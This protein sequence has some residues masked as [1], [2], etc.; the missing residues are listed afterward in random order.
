MKLREQKKKHNELLKELRSLNDKESLD[1]KE[2]KRF[3]ELYK[4]TQTLKTEIEKRQTIKDLELSIVPEQKE[5]KPERRFSLM[6]AIKGLARGRVE[7]F[8]AEYDQ[9]ARRQGHPVQSQGILIPASEVYGEPP[10]LET[11]IV[12]NAIQLVSS[13]VKSSEYQGALY[14]RALMPK[15]GAH[16]ISVVGDFSYPTS[17]GVSSGWWDHDGT[18]SI[19]ESDPSYTTKTLT[20]KALGTLSGWSL[21]MLTQLS[22]ND[23]SLE[24]ILREDM[25]ASMASALDQACFKSTGAGT[26]ANAPKGLIQLLTDAT[27]RET[28]KDLTTEQKKWALSDLT[29]EIQELQQD[30]KM[31][32]S[33]LS[34]VTSP[35]VSRELSEQQKFSQSNG[36]ALKEGGMIIDLPSGVTNWLQATAPATATGDIEV[37]VGDFSKFMIA[38][39]G[40]IELSLGQVDDD[41]KKAI[42]RLRA[43]SL[44]DFSLRRSEF[45]PHDPL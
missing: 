31:G 33:K 14:E 2:Q 29:K 30:T 6:R 34:F 35:L 3:D 27:G 39:Y 28:T 21:K 36:K 11:R 13:P 32:L 16:M 23:L 5:N 19:A 22:K 42:T 7:G 12:D 15:L 8:E 4:S 17:Q 18:G 37:I 1:E 24:S 40:S 20:S 38:Q 25:V 10:E 45:F 41:F 26:Y 44:W 43:I 9:E